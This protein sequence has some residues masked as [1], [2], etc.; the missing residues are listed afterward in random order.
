MVTLS[1]LAK[2]IKIW[3]WGKKLSL[4]VKPT[5]SWVFK[6]QTC[7][8][9]NKLNF[10]PQVQTLI[11]LYEATQN[12]HIRVLVYK[13]FGCVGSCGYVPPSVKFKVEK[14]TIFLSALSW[15]RASRNFNQLFC[16]VKL[17]YLSAFRFVCQNFGLFST[18]L[19]T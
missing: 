3:I 18:Y 17:G 14:A 13:K 9:S 19:K 16:F 5:E 2:K 4:S 10:F 6:P 12:D 1:C 7:S 8:L 15:A 11:F